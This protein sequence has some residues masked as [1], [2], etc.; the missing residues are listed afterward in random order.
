MTDLARVAGLIFDR[1][2]LVLPETAVAL[3]SNLAERFGVE[4]LEPPQAAVPVVGGRTPANR[5]YEMRGDV[6][7]VPVHGELVNRG[8]WLTSASGL[9]SYE[10]LAATLAEAVDDPAV[11][12]ILLDL[13][14]PGGE[15]SGAMETAALVRAAAENKPVV[16][17]VNG[18]AASAG[19]AQAAGTSHI[20]TTPSSQLGSIGVIMMH[21]DRTAA[22][23]KAGVKPTVIHAGAYKAD[24]S[25]LRPLDEDAH[26][27][28]QASVDA[29]YDLFVASVAQHRGLSEKAVRGTEAGL[30]MG[31]A[32]V[33]AGLADEVGTI[34]DALAYFRRDAR[35][36]SGAKSMTEP[37][38]PTTSVVPPAPTAAVA[39]PAPPAPSAADERARIQSI[40][41]APEAQGREDMARHLAFSTAMAPAE[42]VALLAVAPVAAPPAPP[43]P[44]PGSRLAGVVPRPNIAPDVERSEAVE[45]DAIWSASVETINKRFAPNGG[46]N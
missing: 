35:Q 5:S 21:L 12:G 30:F 19:Y 34:A 29:T 23:A 26:A 17:F 16:A 13:D 11:C 40:L 15:A 22:A 27:R 36:S 3:A 10:S 41:S 1:P 18:L 39:P 14:T 45:S 31:A 20:V 46:Q 7:V 43:A 9:T 2:L 28:L 42:A 24:R 37:A 33:R 32:A 44:A 38:P 25:S 8:S 6:A 4:P